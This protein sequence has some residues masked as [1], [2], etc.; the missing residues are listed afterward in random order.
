[1]PEETI[2]ID[3]HKLELA[4]WPPT[5]FRPQNSLWIEWIYVF[6]LE[7]EEFLVSGSYG[8]NSAITLSEVDP[9]L[10]VHA[11]YVLDDEGYPMLVS[12]EEEKE[13]GGPHEGAASR[14]RR[15]GLL[16]NAEA[17]ILAR[18]GLPI[19]PVM[20]EK[21]L[22]F[23]AEEPRA[24]YELPRGVH[25]ATV[26]AKTMYSIWMT[27]PKVRSIMDRHVPVH[28]K[29]FREACYAVL[30]LV[31]DDSFRLTMSTAQALRDGIFDC[32]STDGRL[33]ELITTMGSPWHVP[34]GSGWIC[35]ETLIF[36]IGNIHV[37]PCPG[38]EFERVAEAALAHMV[39]YAREQN[40]EET[41]F[42]V[43]SSL[44][45]VI[46]VKIAGGTVRT[47]GLLEFAAES[48]RTTVDPDSEKETI[49]TAPTESGSDDAAF[50][51]LAA[52]QESAELDR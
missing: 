52:F 3:D 9:A 15:K 2:Y 29:A 43:I 7:A 39:G 20:P 44:K 25:S 6:D 35:P 30:C 16:P 42:G 36:K 51:A 23:I 8:V 22:T 32:K 37:L 19:A 14:L 18:L 27:S 21:N 1:V 26:L 48:L 11:P 5:S 38:I 50:F 34:G 45:S 28:D 10:F 31:L 49:T 46:A 47:N 12:E 40:L 4:T 17:D 24:E 41:F 33:D 13:E